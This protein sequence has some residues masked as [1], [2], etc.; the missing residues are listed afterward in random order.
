M[1]R[2]RRVEREQTLGCRANTVL[3]MK[4]TLF[5]GFSLPPY[6]YQADCEG[7]NSRN[8]QG[9]VRKVGHRLSQR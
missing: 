5:L 2:Q 7:E 9:S 1:A 4:G 8:E 3:L 6:A